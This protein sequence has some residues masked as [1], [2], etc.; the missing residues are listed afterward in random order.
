MS[1]WDL[2]CLDWQDRLR[3]GK[4]L[5]P[6]LPHLNVAEADRAVSYF[7]SLCLP[8]V[9]GQPMMRDACGDWFRDAVRA[10][11]GSWDAPA[12]KRHISELFVLVPKKNSKTTNG[13]ALMLTAVLM[14][15]RPQ[16]EFL[17]VAPTKEI[18]DLAFRQVIGMIHADA[19]L[20]GRFH[21]QEHI[22]CVT[23]KTNKAFLKVKSFDPSVVT[24][25]KPCGVLIDELHD[26]SSASYADRVIG[27]LRGGLVSQP[28][29]FM[30]TIT[31]QSERPPAGVFKS[32]LLTARMVREGKLQ[33][34]ILP[35]L[36]E[37]PSGVDWRDVRNWPLVLPNIGRSIDID[38]LKV[39]FE[40]AQAKGKE[41]VARWA[42]QHLNVEIG[43]ALVSDRW[44]GA[45]FWETQA[46]QGITLEHILDRSEVIEIGIDGGGL[47]DLLGLN[48]TGRDR[49]TKEWL[50]WGRAW[51]HPS[52]LERRKSE[53]GRF[54][55]FSIDGDLVLVERIG[56]D[57]QE[58][59]EICAQVYESGLLDKIGVDPSG[60]GGI[61]E[62]LEE[63]GIPKD[64]VIGISQ[65]WKMTGAI[66]TAER[67]LAEGALVHGGQPLMA[68][69]VGNCKVE[70]RG[71][72]III[73]KQA[74]GTAK[75]DPVL[76]MFNAVTLM[77]L[78]PDPPI[79]VGV[80]Y[81]SFYAV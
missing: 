80:D 25:S 43:L 26:M 81:E 7:N 5:V 16:A 1:S 40:Q 19:Y 70:P 13:A 45:D 32:E 3:S 47:D 71:N 56:D 73:T 20:S 61:L 52:V 41:E 38:R 62:A 18:A 46:R 37:M 78:N 44:A 21:V 23:D 33:S 17:L 29:G 24:G 35:I 63:V 54:T 58:V 34:P 55:D 36:Y 67:K 4:S 12:K 65:G 68:W 2:S 14:N 64:V 11:F 79:G 9:S 51:A 75:I 48:I 22:K 8:D 50:T 6:D 53:V 49:E 76:A 59:A 60:L 15:Q 69:C 66:K 30:V 27:Q 39:L 28:E 74:S 31:T 10:L 42:S 77:S 57:V 72:A